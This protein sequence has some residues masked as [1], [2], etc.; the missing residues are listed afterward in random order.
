MADKVDAELRC[1]GDTSAKDSVASAVNCI[2]RD[3]PAINI[4]ATTSA[5]GVCTV[6]AAQAMIESEATSPLTIKTLRNPNRRKVGVVTDFMP[7]FPRK[8]ARMYN[9]APTELSPNTIWKSRGNRNGVAL[10]EIRK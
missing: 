8:Y 4:R 1:A 10:I 9:P 3:N 2:E 7:R 6:I 5:R